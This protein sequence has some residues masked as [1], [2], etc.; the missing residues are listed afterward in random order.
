MKHNPEVI[1]ALLAKVNTAIGPD[2][3]CKLPASAWI[4]AVEA[5]IPPESA[6]GAAAD[7]SPEKMLDALERIKNDIRLDDP[8][9]HYDLVC[10]ALKRRSV[11]PAKMASSFTVDRDKL[12][13]FIRTIDGANT[14]GAGILAEKIA[15]WISSGDAVTFTA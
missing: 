9:G 13:N 1:R 2:A 12:S 6:A 3:F 11:S 7:Y 15:D 10:E 14:M 5:L 4:A 8:L